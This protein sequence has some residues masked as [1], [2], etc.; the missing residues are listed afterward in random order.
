MKSVT[1]RE[2]E[3]LILSG[4]E[5]MKRFVS[6]ILAVLMLGSVFTV[7]ASAYAGTDDVVY[8]ALGTVEG[9]TYAY[10]YSSDITDS[11]YFTRL[12]GYLFSK[13]GVAMPYGL[14]L[15]IISDKMVY[16]LETAVGMELISKDGIEQAAQLT[17]DGAY[18]HKMTDNENLLYDYLTQNSLMNSWFYTFQEIG[19]IGG[20][21]FVLG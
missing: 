20:T 18:A 12:G 7:S 5:K 17:N 16:P 21:T 3:G 1:N 6:I 19:E 2:V 8:K 15:Y 4:G 11:S 9:Y 13:W 10:G 14:A